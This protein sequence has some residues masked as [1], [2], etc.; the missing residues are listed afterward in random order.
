M[1]HIILK[2]QSDFSLGAT[3]MSGQCFRWTQCSDGY[4]GTVRGQT[5]TVFQQE[6]KITVNG[7]A[8]GDESFWSDYFD[9]TRDYS[10]I[11]SAIISSEPRLSPC[12]SFARGVHILKQ[13]PFEVLCSFIISQNNNIPR[14]RGIVSRLCEGFGKKLDDGFAFPTPSE[15]SAATADDFASLG[16]GYR[17]PYLFDAVARVNDG[18]F[19]IDEAAQMPTALLRQKLLEIHGVGSKVA[20]CVLLY[21]FSRLECFPVDTWIKKALGELLYGTKITESPYAGVAQQY[22]FEYIRTSCNKRTVL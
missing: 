5:V 9:L 12:E 7:A 3:V 16:L 22:I 1:S 17:A 15:L 14:I 2:S 11:N 13:E 19:N 21:G 20:E 18:R 4:K 6:D 8:D 10:A